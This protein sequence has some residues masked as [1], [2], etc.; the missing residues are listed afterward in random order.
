[1]WTAAIISLD[2]KE[3]HISLYLPGFHPGC[4]HRSLLFDLLFYNDIYQYRGYAMKGAL[5]LDRIDLHTHTVKSDGTYT[6]AELVRLAKEADLSGLAITDHD[7]IAGWEEALQEGERLSLLVI[8]GVEISSVWNGK[9]IHVLG[10]GMDGNDPS[11]LQRL[12]ELRDVRHWRNKM[13]LHRLK[14]LGMEITLEE[15]MA[16]QKDRRGNVGR[17]HIAQVM[18]EKGYLPSIQ[19]AF[20]Q[21]LGYGGKAYVNPPRITPHEAVR[22]ILKAGGVPVLA[23]PGLY[24]EDH[25]IPELIEAGLMGIEAAHADHS[26]PMEEKY[27]RIAEEHRLIVTGGSDYHGER[28]GEVFHAP[29]GSKGVSS[30]TVQRLW[31]CVLRVKDRI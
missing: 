27:R 31:E 12:E 17:P 3:H 10:Y 2:F 18:V 19:E 22:L 8:P 14:E 25:L 1:M 13:L 7:T 16:K 21:Y 15:V 24:E 5:R 26:A 20:D 28:N 4:F 6:P 29:L 9:D 11:F 23:H 30:G